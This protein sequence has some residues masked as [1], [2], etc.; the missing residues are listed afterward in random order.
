MDDLAKPRVDS[1]QVDPVPAPQ[2]SPPK[3]LGDKVETELYM[4]YALDHDV[5]F[6]A[7]YYGVSN[8][9]DFK[10]LSYKAE[11]D[12]IDNY[13]VDEVK[14]RKLDN[15]IT[16]IKTRLKQLEKVAGIDPLQPVSQRV[17]T[18]AAYAEYL[19]KASEI[20]HRVEF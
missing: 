3:I 16:A 20:N 17:K 14:S 6:V 9:I 5:P 2:G 8:M 1:T 19:R 18:L 11:V 13:L 15:N 7:D 12:A 10:D 4:T